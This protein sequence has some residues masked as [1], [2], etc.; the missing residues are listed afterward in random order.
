M[1]FK[2]LNS[3]IA[4]LVISASCLVNVA[5]AGLIDR[6]NGMIYDDV[7]D[8]TWMQDAAYHV[9]SGYSPHYGAMNTWDY[10]TTY[11]EQLS[12]GGFDDWRM[13]KYDFNDSSCWENGTS[14]VYYGC[15]GT[16]NEL[17]YMFHVNMG[18]HGQY[19]SNGDLDPLY[20]NSSWWNNLG[21][22]QTTGLSFDITGFGAAAF[23]SGT[24]DPSNSDN[25]GVF[26]NIYGSQ[27]SVAK[28]NH[29]AIWAVRD[30][31][32]AAPDQGG[33]TVPEPSSIA[34]LGLGLMGLVASRK[35]QA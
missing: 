31:D 13:A 22:K 12:F 14:S 4:G 30:G 1:K 5:N 8:V 15:E 21:G 27:L 16:N 2:F 29:A 6:G 23:W 18:L 35:K 26:Y 20:H 17:G 34:I 7:L 33:T 25:A 19:D 24:E 28:T 3:A 11:V 32:V 10:A 9:T